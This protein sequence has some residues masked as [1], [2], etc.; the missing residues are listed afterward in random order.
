M[1]RY[2]GVELLDIPPPPPVSVPEAIRGL[3]ST[4]SV[5]RVCANVCRTKNKRLPGNMQHD[6]IEQGRQ[7]NA[8]SEYRH[9]N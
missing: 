4:R 9:H 7:Q 5:H 1:L 2:L 6:N 3:T 8:E